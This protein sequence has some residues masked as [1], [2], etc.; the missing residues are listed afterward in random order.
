MIPDL[1][2]P[3]LRSF[4]AVADCGSLAAAA[5]R[6]GRSE[7]AISLQMQRLETI[8]GQALFDRDGRALKLNTT[9]GWLLAHSRAILA[10]IDAARSEL[11]PAAKAPVRLGVVQ[12]FVAQVLR[13]T[14]EDLRVQDPA[15]SFSIVIGSTSELLQA[16]SEDRIDTAV[17]AG[18]IPGGLGGQDLA[19]K[20]FGQANLLDEAVVPLVSITPPCPF[21]AAATQALDAIGRPWRLALVTPSLDGVKAAVGSG[22]GIACRTQAGMG[23]DV[24]D[25]AGLP[26]LPSVRYSVVE[27]RPGKSGPSE[28]ALRMA[29]HLLA[30][31]QR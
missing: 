22:L 10:R 21:L 6:V 9:G 5:T 12:D 16:M 18:D 29:A 26:D 14:L 2:S 4:V 28:A 11:G 19:M 3:L 1:P 25:V 27:R 8:V 20:W 23:S 15:R 13:P 17:C 24:P 31:T 30:L 7:S